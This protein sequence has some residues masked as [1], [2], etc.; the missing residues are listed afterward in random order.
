MTP[1]V[2]GFIPGSLEDT[3]KFIEVADRTRRRCPASNLKL[4]FLFIPPVP[5][6]PLATLWPLAHGDFEP[7]YVRKLSTHRG[8]QTRKWFR[9]GGGGSNCASK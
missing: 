8:N 9:G 3:D 5:L 6:D 7:H 1:E 4:F 2:S